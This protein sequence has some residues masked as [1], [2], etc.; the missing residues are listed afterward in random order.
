MY[1]RFMSGRILG[2]GIPNK[3]Q[4]FSLNKIVFFFEILFIEERYMEVENSLQRSTGSRKTFI[5]SLWLFETLPYTLPL[6]PLNSRPP[7]NK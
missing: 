6:C 4:S 5:S 7:E 3:F 2:H 1:I